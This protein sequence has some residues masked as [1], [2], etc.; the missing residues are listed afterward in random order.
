MLSGIGEGVEE[1]HA[2]GTRVALLTHNPSYVVDYYR[3]MFGF[4]DAEGVRAQTT[5]GGRIGPPKDVRADKAG[6]LRA[7]LAR[8]GVEPRTVAH[9]GDGWS[10]AE[11]FRLVGG[12]IALNSS[13]AE[14]NGA[15]DRVVRT[16]DFRDVVHALRTLS[17]RT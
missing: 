17:P 16:R 10:D 14:V 4:D 7:L 15:A 13:L 6:G 2:L 1:L 8:T 12:G 5:D 9:V 11:V 3:Q